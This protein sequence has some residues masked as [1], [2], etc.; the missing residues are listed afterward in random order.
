MITCPKSAKLW[1]GVSQF[2]ALKT[3]FRRFEEKQ[4]FAW[5]IRLHGDDTYG[6]TSEPFLNWRIL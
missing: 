2:D 5:A 4:G 1:F 3:G 6:M